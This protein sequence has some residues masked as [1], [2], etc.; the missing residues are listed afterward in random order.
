ME[1]LLTFSDT[2]TITKSSGSP[3]ISSRAAD[4]R[5]SKRRSI[6][7]LG[8]DTNT[9]F[10]HGTPTACCPFPIIIRNRCFFADDYGEFVEVVVF[11]GKATKSF[12]KA[13]QALVFFG[14]KAGFLKFT[15]IVVQVGGSGTI[16]AG[17]ADFQFTQT[18]DNECTVGRFVNN[19]EKLEK[20]RSMNCP[21]VRCRLPSPSF[22]I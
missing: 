15:E 20:D 14:E 19:G 6:K 3:A 21:V 12:D 8:I 16:P 1:M 18:V 7:I 5:L 9:H 10:P 11:D 17:A 22:C 13:R 2:P 4:C